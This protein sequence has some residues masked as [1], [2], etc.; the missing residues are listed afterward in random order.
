MTR[1]RE[2]LDDWMHTR[3]RGPGTHEAV[4]YDHF[5]E[6]QC[7]DLLA[8]CALAALAESGGGE[9]ASV[10]ADWLAPAPPGR[11]LAL[12]VSPL[13]AASDAAAVAWEA[14]ASAADTLLCRAT[15]RLRA[16]ASHAPSDGAARLP[17]PLPDPD[18][19]PR[20]V[21]YARKEGWPE[22]HA[23]GPVEFRRVGPLRPNREAGDSL[24][25]VSWLSLRGGA[26]ADPARAQAAL[27]FLACFYA[28]WEFERRLGERFV[29]ERFAPL[30]HEA[31]IH[32][33]L[34]PEGWLLLRASSQD[35]AE[36]RA[37]GARELFARDGTRLA[38]V[39]IEAQIGGP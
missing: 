17:Q 26:P 23:D 10:R 33:G 29:Y 32:R 39:A 34:R 4:L 7:G 2:A 27:L 15:I 30:A 24:D 38:S 31:R 28:H 9:V 6:S 11:A 21:E 22:R 20:T 5:G 35:A 8:R 13:G 1:A 19:L 36:G 18:A 3:R 14:R 37:L 16:E 12:R 25:H